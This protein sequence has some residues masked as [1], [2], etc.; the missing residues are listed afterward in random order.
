MRYFL[1]VEVEYKHEL[2]ELTHFIETNKK[3]VTSMNIK[4]NAGTVSYNYVGLLF[5]MRINGP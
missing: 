3:L 5:L 4:E 2:S 1:T